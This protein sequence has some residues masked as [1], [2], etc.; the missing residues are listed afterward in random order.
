MTAEEISDLVTEV[1]VERFIAELQSR[2]YYVQQLATSSILDAALTVNGS[3][4][5][6]DARGIPPSG[7]R[8]II[9]TVSLPTS[10]TSGGNVVHVGVMPTRSSYELNADGALSIPLVKGATVIVSLEGGVTREITVPDVDFDLI[11]LA[12]STPDTLTTVAA[13]YVPAVR[14]DL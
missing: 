5:V 1:G 9:E 13:P 10:V 7:M 8:V 4:R 2:N 11:S 12:L 3:V 6:V 14:R